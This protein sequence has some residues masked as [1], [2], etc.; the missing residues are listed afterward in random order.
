MAKRLQVK[1]CC[2][3]CPAFALGMIGNTAGGPMAGPKLRGKIMSVLKLS[4]LEAGFAIV[5]FIYIGFIIGSA[6]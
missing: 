3:P 5:C 1:A 6:L 2:S 4:R